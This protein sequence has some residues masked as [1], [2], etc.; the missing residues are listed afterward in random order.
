[1]R[2]RTTT[3]AR[4]FDIVDGFARARGLA[5][6][7]PR[8]SAAVRVFLL[9][10]HTPGAE[11][12]F[13]VPPELVLVRDHSGNVVSF[14]R[15]RYPDGAVRAADFRGGPYTLRVR[16]DFHQV[17]DF[18]DVRIPATADQPEPYSMVLD[19]G[20]RYPFPRVS[21]PPA[22]QIGDPTVHALTLLRGTV[23]APD[24]SGVADATVTAPGAVRYRTDADGQWV[25][26][27]ADGVPASA[28][29]DV[30][31][32][33][34]GEDPVTLPDVPVDPGGEA[35]L[36]QTA[37]RGRI[38]APGVNPAAVAVWVGDAPAGIRTDGT[39]AFYFPPTQ[40]ET[41]V[42]VTARLPDGRT[43]RVPDVAVSPRNTTVV[44][45]FSFPRA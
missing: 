35:T 12:S 33:L 17:A 28:R 27:F 4:V 14:G 41:R 44:P 10:D 38:V 3:A 22:V 42:T 19:A 24:G 25:L 8:P 9:A 37:L 23:F 1:M 30:T 34:P 6:A 45:A 11:Q 32:E 7:R 18:A 31:V 2:F 15:L 5:G 20:Y 40:Q 21:T 43:Q 13:D 29:V 36:P 26:V 39:W 16:S